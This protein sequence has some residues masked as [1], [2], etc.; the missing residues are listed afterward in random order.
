VSIIL[1]GGG[2]ENAKN[3]PADVFFIKVSFV[4]KVLVLEK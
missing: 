2:V 3:L 4:P 1:V